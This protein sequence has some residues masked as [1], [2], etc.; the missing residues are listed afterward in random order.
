MPASVVDSTSPASLPLAEC[1]QLVRRL[2]TAV[3]GLAQQAEVLGIPGLEGREWYEQLQRKLL[4]QLSG[5][6]FVVAAVVGG[7]NIGK[8]V[9]FNHLAGVR[10]SATSPL[11]SGT[12]HPTCLVPG[13]FTTQHPLGEIFPGFEL[14][15][16]SQAGAALDETDRHLLFWKPAP[17]LPANLLI[18]DTP[19]IDSDAPV[20]WLRADRV[21]ACADVL[22]AVLTQQ[23]YNDAA[24][25]QFFRKAAAEDKAVIVVFNQVLLPDDEQY[26]PKW[27][28]TFSRE[29]GVQPDLVYIAPNDRRAAE[30]NRLPFYERPWPLVAEGGST[31]ASA[32]APRNLRDDLASLKFRD[33]KLRTLRG[34]LR[35][36]VSTTEGA[37]GWLAEVRRRSAGFQDAST[38]L[39]MQQ[40]ARIDNWPSPPAALFV[41]EI[42]EW[43][44]LHR[45][46]WTK[47]IHDGYS[48]LGETVLAPFSW[49]REKLSGPTPNPAEAYVAQERQ[50]M[51]QTIEELYAELTRLSQ[52]GNELLRPRLEKLLSG[53]SRSDVLQQLSREQGSLNVTRELHEVVSQQMTRFRE[54]SP[55][56]FGLLKKL[57]T[58]AALAR[59]VTSVALF[60]AAAGPAGHALAPFVSEAVAQ[61]LLVHIVGDVAGGAGAMVVG[62]T[63]IT[64]TASGLRVLEARFRQLQ[65]AFTSRRVAWFADFLRRHVLGDLH[66]ELE[67]ALQVPQSPAAHDVEQVCAQL[68]ALI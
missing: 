2:E 22:V 30:E 26:W 68:A 10:A 66:A 52:L 12:K 36:V 17:E 51:L 6:P 32:S 49:A 43:W 25:K 50:L 63:A 3:R 31:T 58:A 9:I 29:T 56:S 1:A 59:P 60:A 46:G 16:W 27:L 19:D 57:D 35:Q 45:E 21:R 15:P 48:R 37:P 28:E 38:L 11:A 47:T 41:N 64:G 4:P 67:A 23:K 53:T 14:I 44:R 39:S 20:N 65:T 24:V 55:G 13:G 54:E 34:S 7:T 40:L 61:S 5:E 62:E 33:I 8:S 42:R 18:L